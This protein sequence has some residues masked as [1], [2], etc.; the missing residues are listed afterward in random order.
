MADTDGAEERRVGGLLGGT[1]TAILAG[2]AAL[3]SLVGWLLPQALNNVA[4]PILVVAFFAAFVGMASLIA[5]VWSGSLRVVQQRGWGYAVRDESPGFAWRQ[6]PR[7]FRQ[8]LLAIVAVAVISTAASLIGTAGYS[9]NPR[10]ALSR[11]EW[12]IGTNHGL[13]NICVSHAR[14]LATGD[15][16]ERAFLGFVAVFLCVESVA[17]FARIDPFSPLDSGDLRP[18]R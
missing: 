4:G 3:G 12:S 5:F 14:W 8:G 13:T 6:I 9:Q 11:C 17:F 16:F 10:G 18:S 1:V 15:E 7:R 2:G